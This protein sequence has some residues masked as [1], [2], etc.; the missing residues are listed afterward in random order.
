[1]CKKMTAALS[2]VMLSV[3]ALAG[4][5]GAQTA[6][7]PT[8]GSFTTGIG[9]IKTFLTGT[10]APALFG[11]AVV[12]LGIAVGLRVLAKARNHANPG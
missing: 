5:A 8:G 9:D 3:V 12:A 6:T 11:L 4:A 7:D 1:M 2:V 10:V